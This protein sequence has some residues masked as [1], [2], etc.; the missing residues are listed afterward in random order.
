MISF[1][2][3]KPDNASPVYLQIAQ[4]IKRGIASGQI[5]DGDEM[6][7]RR[8]LSALIGINPNTVQKAYKLLEDEDIIYS[9]SG[10]KSYIR[11]NNEQS[12]QL[13]NQIFTKEIVELANSLR[14]AGIDLQQAK[15]LLENAWNSEIIE[16]DEKH[17]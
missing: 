4:Y 9:R 5:K 17:E 1:E 3:F 2:F 10:A 8:V 12:E 14:A 16:G 15:I 13:K 7:S 11:I 6:P